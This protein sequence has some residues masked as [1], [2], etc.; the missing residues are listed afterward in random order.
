M[1]PQSPCGSAHQTEVLAKRQSNTHSLPS[2]CISSGAE[3]PFDACP[4]SLELG[5]RRML[6]I[7]L[8]AAIRVDIYA[9][10]DG[11]AQRGPP[12]CPFDGPCLG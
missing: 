6:L 9:C 7:L 2:R 12:E 10:I 1:I 5:V 4:A 3:L 8:C 11:V